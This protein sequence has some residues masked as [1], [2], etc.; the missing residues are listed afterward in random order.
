LKYAVKPEVKAPAAGDAAAA[1]STPA[2]REEA[3]KKL[4]EAAKAI[5][6]Q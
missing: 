4:G 1:E 6:K 3:G 2:E 5:Q